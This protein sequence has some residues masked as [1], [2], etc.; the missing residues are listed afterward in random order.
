MLIGKALPLF[1]ANNKNH[2]YLHTYTHST[3][4]KQQ[5]TGNKSRLRYKKIKN[6]SG[7]DPDMYS[8]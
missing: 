7:Y 4:S 8:I 5:I 6:N 3:M 2:T 1:F